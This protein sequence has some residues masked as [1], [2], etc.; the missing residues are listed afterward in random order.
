MEM[1]KTTETGIVAVLPW[2]HILEG[3]KRE[4]L[5]NCMAY[6]FTLCMLKDCTGLKGVLEGKEGDQDVLL[7]TKRQS[8]S[9]GAT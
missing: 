9:H 7:L 2:P 8:G 6:I 5:L 3:H 4:K 1:F